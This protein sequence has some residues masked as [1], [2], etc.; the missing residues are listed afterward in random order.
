MKIRF[1]F[2]YRQAYKHP[3]GA[4]R[5]LCME[6]IWDTIV[7]HKQHSDIHSCKATFLQAPYFGQPDKESSS[8]ILISYILISFPHTAAC[9]MLK[10]SKMSA[11]KWYVESWRVGAHMRASSFI[12]PGGHIRPC[13][14]C[15]FCRSLL[16]W[17][18]LQNLAKKTTKNCGAKEI[19]VH[20]TRKWWIHHITHSFPKW[21]SVY[22]SWGHWV[23]WMHSGWQMS[24]GTKTTAKAV[25]SR[26]I[27]P[28]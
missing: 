14:D 16:C 23:V 9:F 22:S 28:E 1:E 8:Y 10:T 26:E 5:L 15:S 25:S 2:K 20:M 6:S 13:H 24:A 4:Q 19:S 27:K 3:D 21:S 7:C 12:A 17:K 11:G 18:N